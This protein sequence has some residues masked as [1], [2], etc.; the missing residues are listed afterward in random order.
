MKISQFIRRAT[1]GEKAGSFT[2]S[3]EFP[4]F[5]LKTV[6]MFL[7]S[8]RFHWRQ[9]TSICIDPSLTLLTISRNVWIHKKLTI[10]PQDQQRFQRWWKEEASVSV[11]SSTRLYPGT[12]NF[13]TF[14]RLA[15]SQW[16]VS[17]SH[18]VMLTGDAIYYFFIFIL[19]LLL[20]ASL[21]SVFYLP[22]A[23]GIRPVASHACT[24]QQGRHG[25]VKQEVVLL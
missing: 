5:S 3:S 23:A 22:D 20:Y 7:A 21:V 6:Q 19:D 25:L 4:S 12:F 14:S 1:L 13:W 17:A 11:L 18:Q 8:P 10:W 2:K 9:T 15:T 16:T 24:C